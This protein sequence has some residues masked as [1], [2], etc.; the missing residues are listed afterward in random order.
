MRTIA[1][2]T[3]LVAALFGVA[4]LSGCDNSPSSVSNLSDEERRDL[5]DVVEQLQQQV[6]FSL[7]SPVYIPGTLKP[8]P[9]T[10]YDQRDSTAYLIFSPRAGLPTAEEAP[11]LTA[12]VV[13]ENLDSDAVG[14]PPE[15]EHTDPDYVC[16]EFSLD[17]VTIA[18]ETVPASRTKVSYVIHFKAG[19]LYVDLEFYWQ[20]PETD[21][22]RA[23]EEMKSEAR[24]V[25]RSMLQIGD[26]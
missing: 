10:D 17:N 4:A 18:A 2:F 14:C 11:I 3:I 9:L 13:T 25:V 5:Q 7:L 15:A 23:T 6:G 21:P 20:L 22:L 26:G 12:L 24:L 19:E 1:Q 8:L 16:E